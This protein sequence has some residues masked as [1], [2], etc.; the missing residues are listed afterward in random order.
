MNASKKILVTGGAGYIG[1]HTFV[2]L[3]NAGYEGV[4]IDDFSN[5]QDEVLKRLETIIGSP[6]K[7]YRVDCKDEGQLRKVFEREADIFGAIHFA[8]FKAVG[9]SAR[10]P[11]KYYHNNI[12]SLVT[13]LNVMTDLNVSNLVFSSSCT[14]YGQP[15]KLPVTENT[16][17]K[18]AESPYGETKQIC[19]K[20]IND[21]VWTTDE[22]KAV[23]LRYFNPIGAHPSGLIG[24][25][26]L[27]KP[28]NLVPFITQT[29]AGILD[30]LTVFGND[31][32]TSD[33]TC[34]RDYIHVVDLAKAH[35]NAMQWLSNQTEP[36]FSEI[37]N[38]GTGSGN[39]VLEAIQAFE[40]IS[41]EK[42]NYVIG[43]RRVG[44]IEQIFAN[45]EKANAILGWRTGLSLRDALKDAWGWQKNLKA[46]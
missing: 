8:A 33:G 5:S 7:C 23:T 18:P 32:D 35:V 31:Y 25:L 30:Q 19:E 43:E 17:L 11:L 20:I 37:F 28:D 13:L 3:I 4:I 10:F 15:D 22:L 46:I 9:E 26:P 14:V 41:G 24:E 12:G 29:A 39:T 45:V 6:V 21:T 44:D 27:G 38:I 40:E 1:S 42:L 36:A 16:P 34:V 2:E